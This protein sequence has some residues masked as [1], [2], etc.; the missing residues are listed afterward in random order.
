MLLSRYNILIKHSC[1]PCN[2]LE[3]ISSNAYIITSKNIGKK[4][5]FGDHEQIYYI[6]HRAGFVSMNTYQMLATVMLSLF[7]VYY[8]SF[9]YLQS[10]FKKA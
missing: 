10:Y 4:K 3:Y 2:S 8:I 6:H 5:P 9:V 1:F 7:Q